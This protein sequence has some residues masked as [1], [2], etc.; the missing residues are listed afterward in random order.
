M[1]LSCWAKLKAA[2][3]DNLQTSNY[4]EL[5]TRTKSLEHKPDL[6]KTYVHKCL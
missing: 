5:Q 6:K 2:S 4:P 1:K 3:M